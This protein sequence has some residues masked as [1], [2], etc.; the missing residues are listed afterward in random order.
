MPLLVCLWVGA[1]VAIDRW[2][3]DAGVSETVEQHRRV[4]RRPGGLEHE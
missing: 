2:A 3:K 4:D 1:L